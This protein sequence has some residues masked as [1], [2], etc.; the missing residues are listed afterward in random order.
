MSKDNELIV[1]EEV[2]Y[3]VSTDEIKTFVAEWKD[4]P[5]LKATAGVKDPKFLAVKSA[6]LKAVKFR[7]SIENK[8]KLLKA[9]ALEYGK[10]VDGIAKE[11]TA[12][13]TNTETELFAERSKVERYEAEQ[14]QLRID[15]ETARVRVIGEKITALK[16]IPSGCIG[17][18]KDTLVDV[19]ENISIPTE[20]EFQERTEEAILAYKDTLEKLESMIETAGLA[21]QAAEQAVKAEAKRKAEEDTAIAERDKERSAFN[22]EKRLFREEKEAQ[23]RAVQ[24]QQEEINK[25]K[26]EHEAEEFAKLQEEEAK[27]KAIADKKEDRKSTRLNSSHQIISYAVF[28]LKKKK[29]KKS[30]KK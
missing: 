29:K 16:M 23:D 17:T 19:Y 9:P 5:E 27:V 2:R 11:Y 18:K 24:V 3:P 8:R 15:A 6:H 30:Q 21:E 1:L 20:E 25:Q 4:V 14:E 28:C 13:L 26:A 7:T 10:Q 22:E 12:L